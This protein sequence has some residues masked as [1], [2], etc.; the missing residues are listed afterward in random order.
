MALEDIGCC[1]AYC[2]T[3]KVFRSGACKGCKL[4]YA[5]GT[6]ELAR[7]KCRIKRCCM[8][9]GHVS[10]ADCAR[11]DECETIRAFHEHEGYKYRK[12]RE[13]IAYIRERGYGAFLAVADGW[14]GAYGGYGAEKPEN[15]A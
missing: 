10:C 8:G 9:G 5:D 2:K 12:Y 13:A 14:R 11:Y 3:C 15:R 6:R 4:G 7:A 1:G